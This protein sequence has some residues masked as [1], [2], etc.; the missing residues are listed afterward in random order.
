MP[1][2][3]SAKILLS[4]CSLSVGLIMFICYAFKAFLWNDFVDHCV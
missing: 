2:L 3:K 4:N 1:F